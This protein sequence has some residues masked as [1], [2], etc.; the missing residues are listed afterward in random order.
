[1]DNRFGEY[2]RKLRLSHKPKMTQENLA[3]AVGRGK[4]SISQFEQG[5]NA[6]PQGELLNQIVRALELSPEQETLLFFL[7]AKSRGEIPNDI[8]DYFFSNPAI[9]DAIRADMKGV[10]KINWEDLGSDI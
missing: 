1:M 2:L 9:Y 7:S 10:R 5:K 4:M 3:I 8:K 6:P